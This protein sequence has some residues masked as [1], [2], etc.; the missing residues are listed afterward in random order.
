MVKMDL[1]IPQNQKLIIKMENQEGPAKMVVISL[2][3]SMKNVNFW[4]T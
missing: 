1:I 3:K 4:Q 2:S